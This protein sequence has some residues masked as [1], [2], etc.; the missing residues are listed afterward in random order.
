MGIALSHL[1]A[2]IVSQAAWPQTAEAA[3]PGS[4][5]ADRRSSEEISRPAAQASSE[6]ATFGPV[7]LEVTDR[8]R[9]LRLWRDV[10]GLKVRGDGA[11]VELGTDADTLV[12]LHPVASRPAQRGQSGLYHLAIHLPSEPEFARVLA[13]LIERGVPISVVDYVMSKAIYL[14]D[15]DGLGLEFTL[16]TPERMDDYSVAPGRV[17]VI[18][19]ESHD[20][21]GSDPLLA[22]V[23]SK[24]PD[25]DV[26]RP[27]PADAKIGHVHLHVGNLQA[28][29]EFYKGLGFSKNTIFPELGTGDLGAGGLSKH[30]IGLNIW[31]GHNAPQAPFGTARMR[32]FTLRFVSLDRLDAALRRAP[33]AEKH[34]DEYVVHDPS[35]NR[36]VLTAA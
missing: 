30:R 34:A 11:S 17:A 20:R 36:I 24:L 8:G 32:H 16:E 15:P 21:S 2:Y 31:Q 25:L 14:N 13:R 22:A 26:A 5:P 1:P 23:L 27:L 18:D 4:T 3:H 29:Y 7:H 12:V 9:S 10:V 19:A 35:G 33:H 28:A 6:F